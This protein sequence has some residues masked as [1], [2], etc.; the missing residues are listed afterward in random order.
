M[1]FK[2]EPLSKNNQLK[3]LSNVI[4]TSHNAANSHEVINESIKKL[5]NNIKSKLDWGF[6]WK[7]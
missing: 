7:K 1:F 4:L 6:R 5:I 3:S 2:K